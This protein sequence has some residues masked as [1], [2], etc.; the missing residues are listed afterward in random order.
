MNCRMMTLDDKFKALEADNAPGQETRQDTGDI[1]SIMRGEKLNGTPVDFSHGDIDAFG[2]T[3]GS[4]VAWK[5]GFNK[6]ARQAYTLYRGAAHI[7]A[8]LADWIFRPMLT[9]LMH[10]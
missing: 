1:N 3:P 5:N 6:G 10:D 7:R 2:P 4:E 8:G 9:P